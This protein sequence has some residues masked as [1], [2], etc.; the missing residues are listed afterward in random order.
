MNKEISIYRYYG[1]YIYYYSTIVKLVENEKWLKYE[2]KRQLK[3]DMMIS[4]IFQLQKNN[5]IMLIIRK[6]WNSTN[7]KKVFWIWYSYWYTIVLNALYCIFFNVKNV[8]ENILV[9]LLQNMF[10]KSISFRDTCNWYRRV[11]ESSLL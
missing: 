4:Y 5:I 9:H 3:D 2:V 10:Y 8:L 11:L 1:K 6:Q 7:N